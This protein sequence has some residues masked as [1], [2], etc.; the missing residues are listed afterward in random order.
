MPR[1]LPCPPR[2]GKGPEA[3]HGGGSNPTHT[4]RVTAARLLLHW[5]LNGSGSVRV[6]HQASCEL[7]DCRMQMAICIALCY[8]SAHLHSNAE[9]RPAQ[10][11]ED[12]PAPVCIPFPTGACVVGLRGRGSAHGAAAH[13]LVCVGITP[14]AQTL[15][16][17]PQR[18]IRAMVLGLLLAHGN[19]SRGVARPAGAP[20]RRPN[21]LQSAE[22]ARTTL[23]VGPS[24]VAPAAYSRGSR[25]SA[26]S[27]RPPPGQC[28]TGEVFAS[29][30]QGRRKLWCLESGVVSPACAEAWCTRLMH[31]P[32]VTIPMGHG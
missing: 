2:W 25:W 23:P 16:V 8:C 3:Q 18:S 22:Q 15:A 7:R 10:R 4:V 5:C 31:I 32:A 28:F 27:Q 21:A 19:S 6:R 1:F 13:Q 24:G 29:R 26:A 17:A 12:L 11:D 9:R 14:R 30:L 20:V